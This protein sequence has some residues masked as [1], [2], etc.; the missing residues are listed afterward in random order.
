MEGKQ[1]NFR[2]K[3]VGGSKKKHYY[4]I[5]RIEFATAKELVKTFSFRLPAASLLPDSYLST[6]TSYRLCFSTRQ[7]KHNKYFLYQ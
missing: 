2:K 7:L 6:N 1:L 3:S 4:T 5:Y